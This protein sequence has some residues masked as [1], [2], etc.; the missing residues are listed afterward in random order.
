MSDHIEEE[1]QV[2]KEQ[3]SEGTAL[4]LQ[5]SKS[6]LKTLKCQKFYV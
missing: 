3:D 1:I 6:Q 4:V 5:L 2:A